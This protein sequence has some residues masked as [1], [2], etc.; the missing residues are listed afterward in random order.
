MRGRLRHRARARHGC[1]VSVER[2]GG[3]TG[4]RA[5]G[6]ASRFP[7]HRTRR[8]SFCRSRGGIPDRFPYLSIE[9]PPDRSSCHDTC[10]RL[11]IIPQ[12]HYRQPSGGRSL[13]QAT[14]VCLVADSRR[15]SARWNGL[16]TRPWRRASS[17]RLAVTLRRPSQRPRAAIEP[18]GFS[19]ATRPPRA[20]VRRLVSEVGR[21]FLRVRDAPAPSRYSVETCAIVRTSARG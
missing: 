20:R 8:K 3:A 13:I 14:S 6:I 18:H 9:R 11:S 5:G 7:V 21:F 19:R 1:D 4:V 15:R 16:P 10:A 2:A 12:A 17:E